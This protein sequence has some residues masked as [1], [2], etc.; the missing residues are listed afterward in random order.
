MKLGAYARKMEI[1]ESSRQN[2]WLRDGLRQGRMSVCLRAFVG[3]YQTHRCNGDQALVVTVSVLRD[4]KAE[5]A[6]RK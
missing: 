4:I 2:L 1:R 5:F 3:A 6:E